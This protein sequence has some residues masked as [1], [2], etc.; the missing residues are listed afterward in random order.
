V[1]DQQ[2]DATGIPLAGWDDRN[3]D[4]GLLHHAGTADPY[5]RSDLSHYLIAETSSK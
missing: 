2:L 4:I 1:V 3:F 5:S